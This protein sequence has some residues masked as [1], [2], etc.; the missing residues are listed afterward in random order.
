MFSGREGDFRW[1]TVQWSLMFMNE[2]L[3]T[4]N[5]GEMQ[6]TERKFA[7]TRSRP[8]WVW[9]KETRKWGKTEKKEGNMERWVAGHTHTHTQ[10][11]KHTQTRTHKHL[12]TQTHTQTHT[13]KQTNTHTQTP[14]HT[15]THTQK[16]TKIIFV[17]LRMFGCNSQYPRHY[18][19]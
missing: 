12:H 3:Q 17:I 9:R 2:F 1:H 6:E 5:R 18:M 15:Y 11:N 13:H 14:P 4:T 7:E 8:E 10:R 16:N 19:N